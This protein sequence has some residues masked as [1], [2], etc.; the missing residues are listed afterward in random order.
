[1]IDFQY[2]EVDL[3]G[4]D[5]TALEETIQKSCEAIASCDNFPCGWD[6]C[7]VL[8]DDSHIHEVN[9]RMREVD[10]ATDVLSF[11]NI[12]FASLDKTLYRPK[13]AHRDVETGNVYLGDIVLSLQRA[14]AQSE[15][16]G[17]SFAREAGYLCAHGMAHL[18]GYDHIEEADRIIMRALE[19]KAM[20]A[21]GLTR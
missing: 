11:P 4:F 18:L 13:A 10:R 9:R 6:V 8:T 19:D 21:V 20:A 16:Y 5:C 14:L 15:E 12:N 3:S 7:I 17:H 2:D 1:M